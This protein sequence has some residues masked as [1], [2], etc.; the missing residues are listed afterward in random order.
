MGHNKDCKLSSNKSVV[1]G[2]RIT[3]RIVINRLT[4][5][6]DAYQSVE[7]AGVQGGFSTLNHFQTIRLLIEK[8]H[9]YN[10]PIY[11]VFVDFQN[12]FDMIE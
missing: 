9:E 4:A 10:N 12:T 11:L 1:G 6:F 8:T 7:Q 5:K 2:R 3:P